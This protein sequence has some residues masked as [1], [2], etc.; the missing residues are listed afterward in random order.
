LKPSYQYKTHPIQTKANGRSGS[1][2]IPEVVALRAYEVYCDKFGAQD[3]MIKNGCR[4]GFGTGEL[5]AFLY[6]H[7]FPKDEWKSRVDEAFHG[8]EL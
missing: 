5:I 8:M 1:G 6:A 4:G 3:T 7:S 2:K